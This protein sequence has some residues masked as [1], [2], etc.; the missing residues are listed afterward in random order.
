[1]GGDKLFMRCFGI[2]RN[3]ED[4]RTQFFKL[5]I[6]VTEAYGFLGSPGGVVLGIKI[7]YH[8]SAF[9]IF[10]RNPPAVRIRQRECRCCFAFL[11]CH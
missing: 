5:T 9:K 10:E 11:N 8:M 4:D 7:E 2:G 1:M 6:Q 3:T